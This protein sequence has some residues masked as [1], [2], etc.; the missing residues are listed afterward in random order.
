[1]IAIHDASTMFLSILN[2][3]EKFGINGSADICQNASSYIC[4]HVTKRA[5]FSCVS[6]IHRKFVFVSTDLLVHQLTR[7]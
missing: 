3:S 4:V 1:M 7:S 6:R 5:L 2:K